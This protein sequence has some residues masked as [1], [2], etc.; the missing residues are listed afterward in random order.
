MKTIILILS[1]T[2]MILSSCTMVRFE[3]PQPVNTKALKEFPSSWVGVYIADQDTAFVKS[4]SYKFGKEAESFLSPDKAVLKR[5][6]DYY[7]LSSKQEEG[8]WDVILI[9][10]I[11]NGLEVYGI[12]YDKNEELII[13]NLKKI[14]SVKEIKKGESNKSERYVI[15]PGKREF[16]NLIKKDQFRSLGRLLKIR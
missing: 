10:P 13:D 16:M 1:V 9:K 8:D 12:D 7:V 14:I 3:Q 6:G 11:Y 15:N 2:V 4:N 5:I